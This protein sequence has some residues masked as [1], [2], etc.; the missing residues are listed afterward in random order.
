MGLDLESGHYRGCR[1]SRVITTRP[2]QSATH[3]IDI[4]WINLFKIRS[5]QKFEIWS[6]QAHGICGKVAGLVASGN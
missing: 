4:V 5:A 2:T 6:P 1:S 3:K